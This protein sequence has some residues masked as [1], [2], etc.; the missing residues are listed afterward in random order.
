MRCLFWTTR[1][2]RAGLAGVDVGRWRGWRV[3][4]E[5]LARDLIDASK[6]SGHGEEHEHRCRITCHASWARSLVNIDEAINQLPKQSV[7]QMGK[8]TALTI[9]AI[10]ASTTF[11]ARAW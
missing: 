10:N 9:N 8:A 3:E 1:Q 2:Q 6:L 7:F 11:I 4:E 5:K